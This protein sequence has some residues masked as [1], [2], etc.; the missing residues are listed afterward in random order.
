MLGFPAENCT[1]STFPNF[2]AILPPETELTACHRMIQMGTH[3][4]D[5]DLQSDFSEIPSKQNPKSKDDE[6]GYDAG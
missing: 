4:Y 5:Y 6:S 1:Q 2:S 3:S